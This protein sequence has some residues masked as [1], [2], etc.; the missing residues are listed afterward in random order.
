MEEPQQD[1][2]AALVADL[3]PPVACQP[4][5]R[6]LD[7]VPVA[8]QPSRGLDAAAGDPRG[9][10]ASAQRPPAA[11]VVVAIV[12]V[13]L[14]GPPAGPTRPALR[15]LDR[16]DGIN[17]LLQQQRIMGVGGRQADRQRGPIAVDQQVVL[18]PGLTAVCRVRAG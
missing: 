16:R 8:A 5:Q 18:G 4:R 13:E 12:Q 17:Q 6:P 10:T 3:Q 1:V 2:R 11:R 7:H 14:G 15:P 9:D